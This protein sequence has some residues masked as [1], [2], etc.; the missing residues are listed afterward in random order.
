MTLRI[1]LSFPRTL[2]ASL[3]APV[4]QRVEDGG[5]DEL[6]LIE[7]CFFTSGPALAAAAL[8]VTSRIEVGIGILPAV[9]RHPAITAMELATLAELG[10]GRFTAG[11]GHGVQSWM[12][13]IGLRPSSPLTALEETIVIV[14]QLL[15]GE[16]V[17]YVGETFSCSGVRLEQPPSKGLSVLAGVQGPRSMALA[18]SVADGVIVVAPAS[19]S[20]IRWAMETADPDGSWRT[21]AFAPWLVSDDGAQARRIMARWLAAELEAPSVGFRTLSFFDDLIDRHR[22]GGAEALADMPVDWWRDLGPIGT[23][24]DALE[25]L[26]RVE[27]AGV[28]SVSFFPAPDATEALAD[29]GALVDLARRRS[30]AGP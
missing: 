13:Q 15:A 9:V 7:D 26:D 19:P 11:I 10:G 2:P 5:L 4:A 17:S 16:E 14:K 18:G 24:E 3:V 28:D 20:H 29:V 30:E 6:W 1:G 21:V 22:D 25:Y 23:T 27:A 12:E 8:A